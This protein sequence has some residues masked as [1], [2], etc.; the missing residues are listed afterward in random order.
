MQLGVR[1]F[2]IQFGVQREGASGIVSDT[3]I[4]FDFITPVPK[5]SYILT[6]RPP[7]HERLCTTIIC[8]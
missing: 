5:K 8:V 4:L 1:F 7:L 6:T 2:L 3:L